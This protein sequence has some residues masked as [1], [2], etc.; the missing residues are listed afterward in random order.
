MMD[1]SEAVRVRYTTHNTFPF[2]LVVCKVIRKPNEHA[3]KIYCTKAEKVTMC[4]K[5]EHKKTLDKDF[6]SLNTGN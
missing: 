3:D 6:F 5:V 1:E 4:A 2:S